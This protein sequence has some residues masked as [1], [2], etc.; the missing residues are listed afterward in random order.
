MILRAIGNKFCY[1]LDN[2]N[3]LREVT[4]KIGL[5]RINTQKGVTVEVLDSRATGLVI[6]LMFARKQEFKLKKI[7]SPIYVRNVDGSFNKQKPIEYIMEMN[8]YYQRY[9]KRME[10]D[11][12]SSQKWSV[13]LGMLWF[14]YSNLKIDQRIGEVKMMRCLEEY[15]KQWKLKQKNPGQQ[16]Q[17]K[18]EKWEE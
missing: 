11:V 5:E 9:R 10:I 4:V 7:K 12:I 15:G 13:I 1:N 8:I 16:K 18:D 3:M 2:R 17:K 6:S 14:A